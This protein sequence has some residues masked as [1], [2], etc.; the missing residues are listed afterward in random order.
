M[1]TRIEYVKIDYDFWN[2]SEL[3]EHFEKGE[4]YRHS[5]DQYFKI[6]EMADLGVA[7]DNFIDIYKQVETPITL[8]SELLELGLVIHGCYIEF[9]FDEGMI[10]VYSDNE[11]QSCLDPETIHELSEILKRYGK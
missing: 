6:E 3:K 1:K 8:E 2:L 5:R 7:A 4:L 9:I 10:Q 11:Y